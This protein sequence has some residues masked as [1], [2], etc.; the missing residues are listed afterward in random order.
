MSLYM[1]EY[2]GRYAAK[3]SAFSNSS[4][5]TWR[6]NVNLEYM[7]RRGHAVQQALKFA[8]DILRPR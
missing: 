1:S 6:G 8:Q 7:P 2:V 5:T 3:N 4:P